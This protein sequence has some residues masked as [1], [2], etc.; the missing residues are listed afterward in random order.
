MLIQ[1]N[2]AH[3]HAKEACKK[4]CSRPFRPEDVQKDLKFH[5]AITFKSSNGELQK[6]ST[7][8]P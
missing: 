3:R 7:N 1:L 2:F 5:V 8:L 4:K 6:A